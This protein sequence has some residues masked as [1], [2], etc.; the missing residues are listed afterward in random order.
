MR[1]EKEIRAELKSYEESFAHR[2][3]GNPLDKLLGGH[4]LVAISI[5]KWVLGESR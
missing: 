3:Q 1:T 4:E 5:L 2:E